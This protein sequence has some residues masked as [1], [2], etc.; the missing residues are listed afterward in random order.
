M[1]TQVKDRGNVI[2]ETM[3]FTMEL[4]RGQALRGPAAGQL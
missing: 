2:K 3:D 1:T 4:V